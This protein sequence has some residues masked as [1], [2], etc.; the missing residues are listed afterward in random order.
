MFETARPGT[1]IVRSVTLLHAR[2]YEASH[3]H[4]TDE[5]FG[6]P[7]RTDLPIPQSAVVKHWSR[8]RHLVNGIITIAESPVADLFEFANVASAQKLDVLVWTVRHVGNSYFESLMCDIVFLNVRRVHL[9]QNNVNATMHESKL[10]I[11]FFF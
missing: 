6:Q 9:L 5:P 2:Y 3:L 10:R 11:R 1:D 4:F 7:Q 8:T